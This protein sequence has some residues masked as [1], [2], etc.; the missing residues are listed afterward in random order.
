MQTHTWKVDFS[1]IS[2]VSQNAGKYDTTR[3]DPKFWG[4]WREEDPAF[5]GSLEALVN[6]PL[7]AEVQT[8]LL[9]AQDPWIRS[10]AISIWNAGPRSM[11]AQDK[12]IHSLLHPSR[13]LELVRG[14]V[15]FDAGTKKVAR[16]QQYFSV[17]ETARRVLGY[18]SDGR[19]NGGVIWHTT[20]SGKSLTM[21]MLAKALTLEP[22]MPSQ[23][24]YWSRIA[25]IWTNRFETRS[26]N[27]V[28]W[29]VRRPAASI[30]SN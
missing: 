23:K 26:N 19:R 30:C 4:E 22:S 27:A 29:C 6:L 8:Q 9:E 5:S 2:T 14:F 7:G 16:Y 11:T 17:R 21:V 15:V 24:S 18:A 10:K 28:L 20:G 13:L 1:R 25:W 12:L 3:T